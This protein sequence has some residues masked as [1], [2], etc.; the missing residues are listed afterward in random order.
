M[1]YWHA[2]VA[3]FKLNINFKNI[4]IFG[5]NFHFS[6]TIY[7]YVCLYIYIYIYICI[8]IYIYT[9]ILTQLYTH[10]YIKYIYTLEKKKKKKKESLLKESKNLFFIT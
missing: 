4:H 8:Y 2:I 7:I 6:V 9:H 1:V 3:I 10:T 5:A